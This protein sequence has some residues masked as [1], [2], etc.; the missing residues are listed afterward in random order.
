MIRRKIH[1]IIL[2]GP[3][4]WPVKN[5][6]PQTLVLARARNT[7]PTKNARPSAS[8]YMKRLG[9]K[10]LKT[11]SS[12]RSINA[13]GVKTILIIWRIGV[14]NTLKLFDGTGS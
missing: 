4:A 13:G 10:N 7:A 1:L 6:L 14:K 12:G 11:T 8:V 9:W 5:V 3:D 2:P